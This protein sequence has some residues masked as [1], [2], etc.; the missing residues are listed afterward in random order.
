MQDSA[1][2]RS[3]HSEKVTI[4]PELTDESVYQRIDVDACDNFL[5]GRVGT[6]KKLQNVL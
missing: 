4:Y 5:P 1:E 3:V 6:L 2:E